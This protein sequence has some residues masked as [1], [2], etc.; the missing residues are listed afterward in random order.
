MPEATG[1]DL[2]PSRAGLHAG[3]AA[4]TRTVAPLLRGAPAT[5]LRHRRRV[6][7]LLGPGGDL[8][9]AQAAA[10]RQAADFTLDSAGRIVAWNPSAQRIYG[11]AAEEVQERHISL[12]YAD[13]RAADAA[14]LL[15]AARAEGCHTGIV[16]RR[17]RDGRPLSLQVRLLALPGLETPAACFAE[18]DLPLARGDA[19]PAEGEAER[20]LRLAAHEL[21][22]PLS[23]ILGALTLLGLEVEQSLGASPSSPV[24]DLISL[25]QDEVRQMD[26]LLGSILD[27]WRTR[28]GAFRLRMGP[29]DLREVVDAG[30]RPLLLQRHRV[31]TDLPD[32]AMPLVGDPARLRQVVRNLLENAVKYSPAGSPVLLRVEELPGALR[33]S[34]E[35]QGIGIDDRD[36]D[37]VFERRYRG[38][39]QPDADPGGMGIGL[40]VCRSIIEAHG[41]RIWA[42]RRDGGGTRLVADLPRAEVGT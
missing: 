11:Y 31:R 42:E 4:V 36:L 14:D 33:L 27:A 7:H 12:L 2:N 37:R 22:A 9:S 18:I 40:Y 38:R 21:R 35:D 20:L 32:G 28:Q 15:A 24:T 1:D 13:D 34:V 6:A 29:C 8:L 26:D 30:L 25:A 3:E 10:W 41:G 39:L 23:V 19:P 5:A 16:Q 17:L